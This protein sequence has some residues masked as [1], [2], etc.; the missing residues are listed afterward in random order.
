MFELICSLDDDLM[1]SIQSTFNVSLT[2]GTR[3]VHLQ[4]PVVL[5]IITLFR[6]R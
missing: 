2:A 4:G 1:S 5:A 3:K 6:P